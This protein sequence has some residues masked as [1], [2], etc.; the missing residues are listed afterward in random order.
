MWSN[1]ILIF[2]YT[3][4][5]FIFRLPLLSRKLQ[6]SKYTLNGNPT[7]IFLCKFYKRSQIMLK[8]KWPSYSNMK[9]PLFLK[10]GI[11][12]L[13]SICYRKHHLKTIFYLQ[14]S[15]NSNRSE[16]TEYWKLRINKGANTVVFIVNL[17]FFVLF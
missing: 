5:F 3:G 12:T 7:Y 8:K 17:Y 2:F 1:L 6:L 14:L 10:I 16:T 15:T 4:D 13:C 9:T 11:P